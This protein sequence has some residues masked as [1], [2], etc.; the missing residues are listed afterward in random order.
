MADDDIRLLMNA[1]GV[2][3]FGD[4]KDPTGTMSILFSETIKFR[5]KL[6][7]DTGKIFTVGDTRK[8]LEALE[9]YLLEK[10]MPED[11]TP[12]QKALT[13]IWIDRL[14]LFN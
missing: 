5:N 10:P 14:T 8:A 1:M 13:Q 11:L 9:N 2:P 6:K 12:E 7:E 3:L 4:E